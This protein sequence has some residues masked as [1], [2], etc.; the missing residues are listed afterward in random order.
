[1]AKPAILM[2]KERGRL[3]PASAWAQEQL[4]ALPEGKDLSVRVTQ[5][6]SLSQLG[7]FWA[8]LAL[9]VEN[10][11]DDMRQNF[12]SAR[13]LYRAVLIALGYSDTIHRIDGSTMQ[14]E[15]S[16]AFDAMTQEEMNEFM[17]LARGLFERWIGYDPFAAYIEKKRME[18]DR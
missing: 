16:V 18:N 11:D 7:L 8:G 12:P 1:M 14:V 15:N 9:A 13:K 17:E 4:D 10:F 6:R 3:V 2:R 5:S